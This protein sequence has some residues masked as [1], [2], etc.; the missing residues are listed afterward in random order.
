[1]RK[2][3][4][5]F[6]LVTLVLAA[7]PATVALASP[8]CTALD[9]A[10][11]A[12]NPNFAFTEFTFDEGDRIRVTVAGTG[13]EFALQEAGSTAVGPTAIGNSLVYV[14][15]GDGNYLFS[16]NVT[17]SDA[18]TTA[19]VSCTPVG[20]EDDGEYDGPVDLCHFP[21][22][23]PAAAHTITVGPSAVKA[24]Q[25]HGDTLGACPPYLQTKFDD[26]S[27]GISIFVIGDTGEISIWGNCVGEE[28]QPVLVTTVTQIIN[29][30][31]V[32]I[33]TGGSDDDDEDD[34]DSEVEDGEAHF[35]DLEDGQEIKFYFDD[36]LG[37]EK[38]A[39]I[40]YLHPDPEDDEVGIFQINIYQ[41][42]VLISDDVLIF[43]DVTGSILRWT[44][45]NY[46]NELLNS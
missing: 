6:I 42:G 9:G 25:G 11:G 12:A 18:T 5:L 3:I 29:I 10:S 38:Y 8:G 19:T 35:V 16:V 4:Y 20:D 46:W 21:P 33:F 23:N 32:I 37:N 22:G 44:T 15:P 30:N 40:Y 41:N 39:V 13:T 7:L 43:I 2:W 27:I 45:H 28:C 24:H 14:I 17:G 1:M 36:D 34:D 26:F 31:Q